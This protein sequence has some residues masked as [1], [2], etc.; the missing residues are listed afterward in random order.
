M[1]ARDQERSSEL[2]AVH[3]REQVSDQEKKR[4]EATLEARQQTI[5]RLAAELAAVSGGAVAVRTV[6][7]GAD[8]TISLEDAVRQA[9]G[10][11]PATPG[12]AHA[13]TGDASMPAAAASQAHRVATTDAGMAIGG[14]GAYPAAEQTSASLWH[15]GRSGAAAAP[16][17]TQAQMQMLIEARAKALADA[18]VKAMVEAH[19]KSM[20]EAQSKANEEVQSKAAGDGRRRE[21]ARSAAAAAAAAVVDGSDDD[22]AGRL[23]PATTLNTAENSR[24]EEREGKRA[25]DYDTDAKPTMPED[26]VGKADS[27]RGA[28]AMRPWSGAAEFGQAM[29]L[30]T[31]YA[32]W[33]PESGTM[34]PPPEETGFS[35]DHR[36]HGGLH[37]DGRGDQAFTMSTAS[38]THHSGIDGRGPAPAQTG[39]REDGQARAMSSRSKRLRQQAADLSRTVLQE[40]EGT[41]TGSGGP[42]EPLVRRPSLGPIEDDSATGES[43]ALTDLV[44]HRSTGKDRER[45]LRKASATPQPQQ[46]SSKRRSRSAKNMRGDAPS[47]SKGTRRG[48]SARTSGMRSPSPVRTAFPALSPLKSNSSKRAGRPGRASK[49]PPTRHKR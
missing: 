30:G 47:T 41:P 49:K 7:P 8:Q 39:V 20:A 31:T 42:L 22:V 26:A 38:S 10:I 2:E 46:L 23:E 16:Q 33:V 11:L 19:T 36:S 15:G 9:G 13:A 17:P 3:K 35:V 43:G 29:T 14:M 44:G 21:L 4:L 18:Q 25:T 37:F 6:L 45:V 34:P 12:P 28:V 24:R 27:G 32:T 1:A 40:L 5:G 48:G